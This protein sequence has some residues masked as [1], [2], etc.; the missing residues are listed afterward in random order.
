M[1]NLGPNPVL[2]GV[3]RHLRRRL[4]LSQSLGWN[5]HAFRLPARSFRS[6][7][8]RRWTHLSPH[9][10]QPLERSAQGPARVLLL[11][12]RRPPEMPLPGAWQSA[13]HPTKIRKLTFPESVEDYCRVRVTLR[14]AS[15]R[16]RS[17]RAESLASVTPPSW[18]SSNEGEQRPRQKRRIEAMIRVRFAACQQNGG[19]LYRRHRVLYE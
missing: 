6:L 9:F 13:A 16:I 14:T 8:V 19:I 18:V 5:F 12:R 3:S 17:L 15:I 4:M 11:L 1:G 7:H 10:L 2:M